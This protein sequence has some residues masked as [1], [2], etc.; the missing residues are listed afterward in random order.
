MIGVTSFSNNGQSFRPHIGTEKPPSLK[1]FT[2]RGKS[3]RKDI[4]SRAGCSQSSVSKF[5]HGKV[6]GRKKCGR[7]LATTERDNRSLERI[8]RSSCFNNL[9][10]ITRECQGHGV[11]VSRATIH[12]DC[13]RWATTAAFQWPSPFW[14]SGRSRRVSSGQQKGRI[15][16]WL[17][18]KKCSSRMKASFVPHSEIKDLEC[19]VWRLPG[20]ENQP[21]CTKSSV[22]F[23]QSVMV[24]GVMAAGGVGQLCFLKSNVNAEAYQQVLKYFM[25]PAGE[26][27]FICA[28]FT[29]QQDLA[30]AH[31]ARSTMRWLLALRCS[32]GLKI[33]QTSIQWRICGD[34]W[35]GE[36]RRSDQAPKRNSKVPFKERGTLSH[37]RTVTV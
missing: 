27:I 18:G 36:C 33:H 34:W 7:K 14:T 17:A 6:V 9:V 3:R 37:L 29:F 21:G 30:P 25:L 8:V 4:A 28:D 10:E 23:S 31:S 26:E 35:K 16:R 13:R 20:E 24:W 32:P 1:P 22:K 11:T 2:K 12:S 5:L 19:R 15:G